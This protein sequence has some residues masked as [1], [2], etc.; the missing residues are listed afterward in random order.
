M[1]MF[2]DTVRIDYIRRVLWDVDADAAAVLRAL[3]GRGPMPGGLDPT[4]IYVKLLKSYSWH[5]L[6]RMFRADRLNDALSDDVLRRLWPASLRTRYEYAREIL[7]RDLVNDVPYHAGELLPGRIF[8]LVDNPLNILS[9]KIAALPRGEAKDVADILWI[10]RTYVFDWA[11]IM[12][13]AK[14]KDVWG[15]ELDAS[16][17]LAE[18]PIDAFEGIRWIVAPD[19]GACEVDLRRIA[20]DLALGRV[21]GLSRGRVEPSSGHTSR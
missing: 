20:E 10:S 21:N 1:Q 14:R 3:D 8:P 9:N 6:L 12:E 16:R 13:E 11:G 5:T 4:V 7:K 18:F 17:A 19:L 2:D 15:D